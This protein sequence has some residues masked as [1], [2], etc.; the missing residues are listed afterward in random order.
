MLIDIEYYLLI[1]IMTIKEKALKWW[2]DQAKTDEYVVATSQI[3]DQ[4]QRQFLVKENFL[5]PIARSYWILKRPEDDIEEVFPLLYW[6]A[7]EKIISRFGDWSIWGRSAVAILSGDERAQALLSVKT[8]VKTNRN[9]QLPSDFKISLYYDPDFDERLVTKTKIAGRDI[10]IDVPEKV[11]IDIAKLKLG[12]EAKGFIAGTKFDLRALDALYA[13]NPRPIVFKR[14]IGMAKDTER[15]DLVAGLDR[16]ITAHTHYQVGKRE[17]IEKSSTEEPASLKSPWVIRQEQQFLEFEAALNKY[18]SARIGKL[19]KHPVDNL[20]NQAKEHKKYDAYHSTSLEGYQ[21]TPEEV[22]ALLS[23]DAPEEIREQDDAY[24]E[25]LK[26]RMAI[27]GYSEAFDFIISKIQTDFRQP[28]FSEELIKEA[29]YRL[30]KPSVDAKI[31]NYFN[32][33]DY[34]KVAVFIRRTPYVP[35]GYEKLTELMNDYVSLVNKVEDPVVK[36]ILAH[37]FFVTIH[38]YM[39]GNGRTARLLMNYLLVTAGYS[40]IT[41]KA[42]QRIDYFTALSKGQVDGDIVPFGKFIIEMLESVSKS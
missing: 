21:I 29:Y 41:I 40:W 3:S 35:P 42:E 22:D 2:G 15:L 10:P 12:S 30:F 5:V 17:K 19:K 11:L 4:R 27:V 1:N 16:I 23:G 32:L 31:V 37:W 7:I 26:N 6:Q 9:I 8:K 33:V 14:L 28:N 13:M 38:P 34:R 36:A 39:D 24:F 25:K 18:F 20:L